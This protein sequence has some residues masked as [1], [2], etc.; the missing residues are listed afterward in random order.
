MGS[1]SNGMQ[2]CREETQNTLTLKKALMS[3]QNTK[4]WE[5]IISTLF[6]MNYVLFIGHCN[7]DKNTKKTYSETLSDSW[8]GWKAK[9]WRHSLNACMVKRKK[10]GLQLITCWKLQSIFWNFGITFLKI[11]WPGLRG[12]SFT[13]NEWQIK[14]IQQESGYVNSSRSKQ[15]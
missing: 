2:K 1:N 8:S 10:R 11:I 13:K 4:L 5:I 9:W 7:K 15:C 3:S 12:F 6:T 14:P